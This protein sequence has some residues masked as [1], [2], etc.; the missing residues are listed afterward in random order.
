MIDNEDFDPSSRSEV[1]RM[2]KEFFSMG[3]SDLHIVT[4]DYPIFR[5][6]RKP[7]KIYR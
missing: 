6:H 3:A 7:K 5:I 2:L 1:D 4:E